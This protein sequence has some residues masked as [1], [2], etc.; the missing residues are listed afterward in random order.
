MNDKG[1]TL[2][3]LLVV[4]L[5]MGVLAA[6]AL[7]QYY[8]LTNVTKVKANMSNLRS[9]ADAFER[10]ALVNGEYPNLGVSYQCSK[11]NNFLDINIS[12]YPQEKFNCIGTQKQVVIWNLD[13]DIR[14]GY[15]LE[16][17]NNQ[18]PAKKFFC[19]YQ[20]AI[21]GL[22]TASKEKICKKVCN[23]SAIT[24]NFINGSHNGCVVE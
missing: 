3:E 23:V 14:L 7:P 16:T 12:G 5:I 24:S 17:I 13:T 1:F 20:R 19:Y 4:V 9:I 11:L 18:I 8:Y 6:I 22:P 2:I 10:Y 15:A 21:Q